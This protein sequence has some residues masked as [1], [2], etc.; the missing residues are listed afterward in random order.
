MERRNESNWTFRHTYSGTGMEIGVRFGLI[1][2][3]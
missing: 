3:S 2:W 1:G